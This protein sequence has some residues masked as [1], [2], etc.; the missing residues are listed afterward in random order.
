MPPSAL[1]KPSRLNISYPILFK[2]SNRAQDH[3]TH[4]G[5]LEFVAEAG[6]IYIPHW[7]KMYMYM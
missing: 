3:H 2:L 7:V 1:E 4:C 5:V 6:R